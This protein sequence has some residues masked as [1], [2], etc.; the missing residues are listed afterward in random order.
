MRKPSSLYGDI[1]LP[2]RDRPPPRQQEA[3]RQLEAH[4]FAVGQILLFSPS[5]VEPVT[6][7]GAYS[8]V[9]LMPPDNGDN[10]YRLKS[11]ADGHERVVRESQLGIPPL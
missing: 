1:N 7:R 10:Q 5:A 9:R 3:R 4:K 2:R 8:V 11:V 6:A